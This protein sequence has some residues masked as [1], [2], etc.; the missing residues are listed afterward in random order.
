MQEDAAEKWRL[1][2]GLPGHVLVPP[3]SSR[4]RREQGFD[5]IF[6][7]DGDANGAKYADADIVVL[8]VLSMLLT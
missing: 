2:P 3:F 8:N 7:T 5:R 4:M 6:V 1:I